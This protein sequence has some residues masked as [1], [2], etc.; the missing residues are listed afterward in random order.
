MKRFPENY[1]HG[2]GSW[3]SKCET[4]RTN[5]QEGQAENLRR[6]KLQS[7]VEFLL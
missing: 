6:R 1:L 2:Y 5:C 7:Q 3:L 4:H